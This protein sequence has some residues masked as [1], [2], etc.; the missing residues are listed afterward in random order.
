MIKI[1]KI[2]ITAFALTFFLQNTLPVYATKVEPKTIDRKSE[3]IQ[4]NT[5]EDWEVMRQN[6]L[7][8]YEAK[9]NSIDKALANDVYS[10]IANNEEL[11]LLQNSKNKSMENPVNDEEFLEKFLEE[12]P[13]Y[14]TIGQEQLTENVKMLRFNPVVEAVRAFFKGN[15]YDL[16]LDL[17]N[18]S[19]SDNPATASLTLTGNTAGMYGHIRKELT[20]DP[21]LGKM[22]TF[23]TKNSSYESQNTSDAFN[24]GDLYWSIHNFDLSRTRTALGKANF[25]I[26]DTYDFNKWKDIPGIVAGIAGTHDFEVY[27]YGLVQNGA[28]K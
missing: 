3:V 5:E 16:S 15:G 8:E 20:K 4:L 14:R 28:I 19:L 13:E 2:A 11:S 23:A 10:L 18:H 12:Y 21:F 27:I 26:H 24:N 6:D 7:A 1:K 22:M 25:R 17:F 9:L